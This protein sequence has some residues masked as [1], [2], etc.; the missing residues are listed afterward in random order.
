MRARHPLGVDMGE[1]SHCLQ[2]M[3]GWLIAGIIV[4]ALFSTTAGP[5][6]WWVLAVV[7]PYVVGYGLLALSAVRRAPV[8]PRRRRDDA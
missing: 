1:V 8:S 4:S 7:S 5:G 3:F 2:G 6:A